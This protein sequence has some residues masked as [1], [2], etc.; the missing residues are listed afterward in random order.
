MNAN[1][2]IGTNNTN[3]MNI[4]GLNPAGNDLLQVISVG[5]LP[6]LEVVAASGDTFPPLKAAVVEA[7]AIIGMV[8]KFKINKKDWAAFS[9]SLIRKVE[10]IVQATCQYNESRVPLTLQSNVENLKGILDHMKEDVMK[11]QQQTSFKRVA[12]FRKDPEQIE[13]FQAKLNAL[14]N[15][16]ASLGVGVEGSSEKA[17]AKGSEILEDTRT[18]EATKAI[19]RKNIV[20]RPTATEN[21]PQVHVLNQAHD[22]QIND[23]VF[24][25]ANTIIINDNRE[26]EAKIADAADQ[27]KVEKWLQELR[28]PSHGKVRERCMPGTRLD[29][30]HDIQT[31]LDDLDM[32]NIFWLSGS[33]GSGKTTIAST[34]VAGFHCFSGQFFF[35][36]DEAELRDPDNLWR[37]LALDLALGSNDLKK[38][39]A[40]ALETQKA[41]IRGFD[42]SMQFEHFIAQPLGE[43]FTTSAKPLLIVIDALDECDSYEKLL[44]SLTSWSCLPKSLKLLITSRHYGDIQSSLES[45]SVHHNLHTGHEISTQTSDDLEKYFIARFSQVTRLPQNW[46]G[47][48]KVSLLVKKVAGLFIWAKSAMDFILNKGGDPEERL[49][50]ISAGSGEEIDAVDSL[51]HQV[52]SVALQGLRKSEEATLR[53]VLGSIV[54]AKNPLR[55][56]DLKDLL[57]VKD[58]LLNSIISQLRPILSISDASYVHVCHQSVADF[59]VDPKRS[60]D[61]WIDGQLHSL[62][63]AGYC[64]KFMNANLKFNFFNL[65]TSYVLNKDIP[66]LNEHIKRVKSTALDHASYFWASYL[67]KICNKTLQLETQAAVEEF[68]MVHLLH[69]LEVMSLMGTVNHAAQLLLLAASWSRILKCSLSDFAN[70]ASRFVM[71]FLEP[72]SLAAPHIYLSAL[73]FA[74]QISKVSMCFMKL[75][76]RTLTVKMGQMDHW[77]EKCVLRLAGHNDKV[78]SVAFSPDGRHIVSGSWDKTIRVWDAQTGQSV[79][80]P[81]K[82]H[83]DRVTSVAFSPDG[84]HIVSGSNDKTVRVWDAQTGQSVMDPLKGHDAY[85]T[86]VRFSPDGRHIVSGSDDSTIR[87]WDAQTG[88]SVMDP[89]KGHNDTVASVA[90]SPDGRHIVS[91]SWDKTIRVWDAQTVAFSPD[92][93]H[94]VSGSWDKT[95]RVWD[96]QTGQRV[97][98]PLR[99]IVSGSWDETVRVWDAQTGQSVM[100]PFKGHDDYVASVAFSPDGR[101]IVSGSWDKTIRVWDAQTGQS[102]MDPFKGHD[103]IVTSVAFSPDGRHIV[104]GSCDKTVRVWDAQTG[105][106]VMGPFKGHDDTVTSVAFSPDG[107]HIVSGSWD[108]TVRVWDAQTGQSVMDPLKGHNG[109]V[110]SVAFSPNGRHIVSGSWDETVRVWDAQTGQSVMDPL[111]GHNGRVTSVAFSPNGRHIVSG[112]WDKSVRVWDAQTGQSV[113]DPLKGHNGRVTSVAF[114]PNGRHIVSGS[115]DKTAR[116]WDAQTGQSVINSFKGHDLW[117]TSVGLS[118]HGRHTVPEFGDKTVQVAEIDQTIMDPFAVSCL[119]PCATSRNPIVLPITPIYSED[120]NTSMS[121]F[122]KPF[123]CDSYG[124][125]LKFCHL[126]NNWIM[127]PDNTYLLWVPHQNQS[128]LFWPRTTTVIGCTPTSLQFKNFVHG[129]NWS[130][131]FSSLHDHI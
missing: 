25:S 74:P 50:I 68:L 104:S 111:K 71:E 103:D 93:R 121:D 52:I 120:G 76:Q 37:R 75:F 20:E 69:W 44:P 45:V 80:D 79:I 21:V 60:K 129:A 17:N 123:L 131:C 101:H 23:S 102:V 14:P 53:L 115:W 43:I 113:I 86:S 87:V 29:V 46:P 8:K 81:L 126:D 19:K 34:V 65:K 40:Q 82:G 117:V 99:R 61:F 56:E 41:N 97:M 27:L 119:S 11:I 3:N 100:D 95:V 90:F 13:R 7:L 78:A 31:W 10:E 84:R 49:D 42:I 109:R 16:Q 91:G 55:I 48:A 108:E 26:I 57:E 127:L 63:F 5:G 47:P 105:Q 125:L 106:R 24:N 39:I 83:D 85:V 70:D 59:L 122:H 124:P 58:A 98:G 77:S 1:E 112:S 96:A 9:A 36:R 89:F 107:R 118:S 130:Q 67:Q 38:A 64:L 32:H 62:R 12:N 92:G 18:P 33:P 22:F 54:I 116:V 94:I 2:T 30:L 110:T 88:Q 128:G 72:I 6:A 15:F 28:A 35:H 4:T 73:P 114:S 66:E 51:Y